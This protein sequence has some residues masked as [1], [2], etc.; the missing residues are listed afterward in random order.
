MGTG[1]TPFG[2]RPLHT[3]IVIADACYQTLR[4]D[5]ADALAAVKSSGSRTRSS[6]WSK[7]TILMSGL[8]S[9]TEGS[10]HRPFLTRGLVKARG[11]RVGMFIALADHPLRTGAWDFICVRGL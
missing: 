5:A 9:R 2:T 11:G 8:G 3:A 7:P 1:R 4:A 6:L 10:P